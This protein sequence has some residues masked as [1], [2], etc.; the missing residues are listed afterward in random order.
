MAAGLTESL[1]YNAKVTA[2]SLEN[3]QYSVVSSQGTFTAPKVIVA[4][5]PAIMKHI[6]FSP[7]LPAARQAVHNGYTMG[8]VGKFFA[9]YNTPFWRSQWK[10]GQV[11]GDGNPIDVTFESYG[12]G[13]HF[14]MGFISHDNM[15]RLDNAS[16]EQIIEE[17]TRNLVTYFGSQAR[18][19]MVDKGLMLWDKEPFSEGGPTGIT[20][21]GVLTSVRDALVAPVGGIHWAG[22]ETA[23]YWTGYMDGAVTSGY[24]AAAEVSAALVGARR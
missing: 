22:T 2:I 5:S 20:A 14:L 15:R 6:Q 4:M 10:S 23:T 3:D 18:T 7:G 9:A 19:A 11:I 13:Q 17:C 1:V 16:R 24:R 8:A 21:P 12:Q